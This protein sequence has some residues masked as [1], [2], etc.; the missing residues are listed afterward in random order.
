M[1][2]EIW[3]EALARMLMREAEKVIDQRATLREHVVNLADASRAIASL[4]DE[5]V[6]FGLFSG[7]SPEFLA[8]LQTNLI[9][10]VRA[11]VELPHIV[12]ELSRLAPDELR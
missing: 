2:S 1:T 8:R 6:L 3:R 12:T 9:E 10:M 4:P 11:G 7:R 5:H